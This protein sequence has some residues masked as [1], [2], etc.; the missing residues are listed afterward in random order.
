VR[1]ERLG[2]TPVTR[3]EMTAEGRTRLQRETTFYR[4]DIHRRHRAVELAS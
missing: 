2:P 3:L 4:V 1:R